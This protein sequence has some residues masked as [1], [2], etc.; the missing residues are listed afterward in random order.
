MNLQSYLNDLNKSTEFSARVED[1]SRM[2]AKMLMLEHPWLKV[3]VGADLGNTP[4][5]RV[6]IEGI[7]P[8]Y[9]HNTTNGHSANSYNALLNGIKEA[10][11]GSIIDVPLYMVP[12]RVSGAIGK[13]LVLQGGT[14]RIFNLKKNDQ[15]RDSINAAWR[16]S[17]E[18]EDGA[19]IL[20]HVRGPHRFE[21]A[22]VNT[23][24]GFQMCNKPPTDKIICQWPVAQGGVVHFGLVGVVR[25]QQPV[26]E[27]WW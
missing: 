6:E 20:N 13:F 3:L 2:V 15:R 4:M 19:V 7:K 16:F 12:V 8:F 14:F 27:M 23:D 25:K 9:I 5:W 24:H 1:T 22:I 18:P 10:V 17:L 11:E 26:T 21:Q